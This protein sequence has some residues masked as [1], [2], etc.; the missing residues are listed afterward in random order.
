MG[1]IFSVLMVL[2]SIGNI[3]VLVLLLKRR[4]KRPSRIDTMLTHLAIADLLVT[5]IMMPLEI[6]WAWT[7][8][9]S[10]VLITHFSIITKRIAKTTTNYQSILWISIGI[11]ESW[12]FYVS[13]DVIS[14][15]IWIVS[16]QFCACLH[17]NW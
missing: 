8:S 1:L 11:M 7:V 12:W 17:F 3:T 9:A 2:S 5:F 14:T 16:V 6:G 10:L 13:S 4:F 15:Y